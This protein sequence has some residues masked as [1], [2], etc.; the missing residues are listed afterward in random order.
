LAVV[1]DVAAVL[2]LFGG[3]IGFLY[4]YAS[5]RPP[6]VIVALAVVVILLVGAVAWMM[7]K[8]SQRK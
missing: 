8:L 2:A 5:K 4:W 3:G 1:A 7:V 6:V